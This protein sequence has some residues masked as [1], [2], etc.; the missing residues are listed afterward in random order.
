MKNLT[1]APV[2][3]HKTTESDEDTM[4]ERYVTP[5]TE[6]ADVISAATKLGIL[7]PYTIATVRV[8]R[9]GFSD[10]VIETW[11]RNPQNGGW[12]D[13][14]T[15]YRRVWQ[16]GDTGEMRLW[17]PRDATGPDRDLIFRILA[18]PCA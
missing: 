13:V 16:D 7:A 14:R 1:G 2:C 9:A 8:K 17:E 5:L 15:D 10:L 6:M 4:A 18:W 11:I 3:L 12:H